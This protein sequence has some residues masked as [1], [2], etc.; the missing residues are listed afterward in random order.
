MKIFRSY[1]SVVYVV[2]LYGILQYLLLTHYKIEETLFIIYCPIVKECIAF[3]CRI[4]WPFRL[5]PNKRYKI[6]IQSF[7]IRIYSMFFSEAD[8]YISG[9]FLFTALIKDRFAHVSYLE[10][11]V[12]DYIYPNEL[13]GSPK[14]FKQ[15]IYGKPDFIHGYSKKVKKVYMS[16]ILPVPEDLA[17]KVE[18]FDLEALWEKKSEGEKRMI[19]SL[20]MPNID[21][22]KQI[23]SRTILLLTQPLS[24]DQ[25]ISFDDKISI[26]KSLVSGY[27]EKQLVIKMHPRENT[28]YRMYFPDACII[29]SP[30]PV[31]LLVL[32][33][34]GRFKTVI[35][36]N[37][38]AIYAFGDNVEKVI[39]GFSYL[40]ER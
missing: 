2:N 19:N 24:E 36:V 18:I 4:P 8:V 13:R 37:S 23:E 1:K 30:F 3:K 33:K 39:S 32:N 7:F 12:K 28:D 31:E 16:G 29:N 22:F 6:L 10:E 20:L 40:W 21:V 11:G 14:W 25:L 34:K 9:D 17:N 26:Y 5:V 38:T 27:D 35:T 15:I